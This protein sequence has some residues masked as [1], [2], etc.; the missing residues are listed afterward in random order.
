MRPYGP[1]QG[2]SIAVLACFIL[3]TVAGQDNG[4]RSSGDRGG[5]VSGNTYCHPSFFNDGGVSDFIDGVVLGTISTANTGLTIDDSGWN[6]RFFDG[7]GTVT[8]LQK[9]GVLAITTGIAP[10]SHYYAWVDFNR[11]GTFTNDELLGHYQGTGSGAGHY[12]LHH[13]ELSANRVHGTT[14]PVHHRKPAYP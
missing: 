6:D 3:Q 12:F 7:I 8:S 5:T 2:L 10:N 4:H 14:H 13:P 9:G 1:S 11:D